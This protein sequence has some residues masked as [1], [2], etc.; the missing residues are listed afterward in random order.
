MTAIARWPARLI[1]LIATMATLISCVSV[2]TE[3]FNNPT[4]PA[5]QWRLYGG[6]EIGY[7]ITLPPGW[8]AF[9]LKTQ[10]DL[11]TDTCSADVPSR[12]ARREYVVSLRSNGVR[13]FACDASRGDQPRV[14]IAYAV[15]GPLPSEGV[16]KYLDSF[17]Q[18]PGREVLDRRHVGTNAG[19]MLI[20][21]VRQRFT[22]ADGTPLDSTHHQ[23]IVVRFNGLHAL[24]IDV[25]VALSDAVT[26]DAELMGMSFTPV[27]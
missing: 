24:F 15:T 20:Q 25:P 21:R 16:E 10:I 19:E 17:K 7:A 14:P 2:K 12:D 9:D 22:A 5:P 18:L 11:A 4:L 6:L 3:S 1:L 26:K 8:S 13:L 23:F 27:R